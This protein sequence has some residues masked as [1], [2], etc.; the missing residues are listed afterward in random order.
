VTLVNSGGQTRD[1]LIQAFDSLG[2]IVSAR[3]IP[4][5]TMANHT[6]IFSGFSGWAVASTVPGDD[7]PVLLSG[8]QNTRSADGEELY[9]LSPVTA[10]SEQ[11][12]VPHIAK[13]PQFFT[14]SSIV[15]LDSAQGVL[16]FDS[17]GLAS[18]ELGMLQTG[19]ALFFDY[20][21]DVFGGGDITGQGWGNFRLDGEAQ[22]LVGVEVF[23][24]NPEVL[25]LQQSVGV[26]LSSQTA[27]E[28]FFVHIA[29]DTANF[30]TGIVAINLADVAA[31]VAIQAYDLNG[32]P[33]GQLTSR[34]F[35]A[36]EKVTWAVTD[37]SQ[38][39]GEGAAWL[40]LRSDQPMTGYELFGT[41][42]EADQWAGF[43]AVTNLG[44]RLVIPHLEDG[45]RD[46]GF[47]GIAII[48][49]AESDLELELLL[50]AG[51][52]TIKD[53]ADDT[54]APFLQKLSIVSTLFE[55]AIEEGDYVV[56][57]GNQ[58]MAG[59]ELYGF[60]NRTLGAIIAPVQE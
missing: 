36:G 39:F 14:V 42:G 52:G 13:D 25:D 46:G 47:T 55:S 32:M 30:W 41:V 57:T 38:P 48:N 1:V 54:V 10:S 5:G 35:A 22:P 45:V 9:A 8:V 50:V 34:T 37:T 59:F 51:D 7:M 15:N 21:Q 49:P 20:R 24:R 40:R 3:T 56:V 31:E 12:L 44:T 26:S 11:I 6:E 43:E 27:E 2:G 58:P 16:N 28:L 4:I 60:G 19:D 33:L 18:R 23:G 53:T 17:P 29:R